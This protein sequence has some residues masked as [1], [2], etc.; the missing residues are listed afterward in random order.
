MKIKPAHKIIQSFKIRQEQVKWLNE[1]S[2]KMTKVSKSQLVC[3]ALEMYMKSLGADV[4]QNATIRV[5]K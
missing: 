3:E 2:A 4:S 5:D 1:T